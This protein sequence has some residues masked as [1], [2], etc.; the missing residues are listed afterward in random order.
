MKYYNNKGA[1]VDSHNGDAL[2]ILIELENN[3]FMSVEY[4]SEDYPSTTILFYKN[5]KEVKE[6][7]KNNPEWILNGIKNIKLKKWLKSIQ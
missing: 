6:S 4:S 1:L 7:L 5:L 2:F 3:S